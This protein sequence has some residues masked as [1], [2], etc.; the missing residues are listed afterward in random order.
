MNQRYSIN[1][2]ECQDFAGSS[3]ELAAKDVIIDKHG[4]YHIVIGDRSYNCRVLS[5]DMSSKVLEIDIE[6][7]IHKVVIRDD[8]DQLVEQMGLNNI[9]AAKVS[10]IAAPMPGM[11]LEISVEEGAEVKAGE[12]IL[13][14]EAMKMENI[15]K[16]PV[17]CV[18]SSILVNK[19]DAVEK[20]QILIEL[21]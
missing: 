21:D 10:N 5:C 8:Y 3:K 20:N 7:A 13:I 18:I 4:N 14:L 9:S 17:D 1:V 16:A 2:D 15:L 6:G 19:G 11:V 12:K